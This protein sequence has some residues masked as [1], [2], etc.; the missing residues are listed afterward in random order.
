MQPMSTLL[1]LILLSSLIPGIVTFLIPEAHA[2]L[3]NTL[4][5]GAA[6]VKTALVVV[7]LV[8]VLRGDL[9]EMR[10]ALLPGIDFVLHAD[11]WS[12]MFISLSS[13]LWLLTT[14]YA[15][16]YLAHSQQRSRFFG[17]FSLCVF[18]TSGIALSG[19]LITF[20]IFY[21]LLTLATYPLVVHK[22]NAESI[23]AGRKYLAYTLSGGTLFLAGVVWL[24]AIAGPIEFNATGVLSERGDLSPALLQGIFLLL[25]AGLGVK[26]ALVPL[27]G[28]LPAAM[29]APA[30]VS[31]LLHAVAVVKAGAF[32]I[33]RIVYD[34]YGVEFAAQLGVTTPLAIAASVTILYGSTLALFQDGLKRRLAFSTVSQVSYIALG[35]AIAGPIATIGGIVHLVHQGLMKIT[36]F[37]CAGNLDETLGIHKISQMNGVGRRMPWTM[38]AFTIAALGMIGVPPLAGF[39]SKWYLGYGALET[40]AYWVIGVLIGSSLL[41]AAY[42]LPI[43]YAAWFR[44]AS[45]ER[46]FTPRTGRLE[47][48]WM[49]LLPPL[50]TAA[51]A[52]AAGIFAKSSYSPLEWGKLI[53]A[54]EYDMV[55]IAE[56]TFT[57]PQW[58]I[59]ASLGVP[60]LCAS[61]ALWPRLQS[62]VLR[63][64][65]WAALP[66][67]TLALFP[68]EPA[69]IVSW[70]FLGSVLQVDELAQ[71]FLLFTA[72]L[73]LTCGLYARGYLQD[74]AQRGR[75]AGFFLLAMVGNFGLI[76]AVDVSSFIVFFTLM[77]FASYGLVVH[78]GDERAYRAGRI[79]I[80][81]VVVGEMC[82]FA[83]VVTLVNQ[84]NSLSIDALAASLD[85]HWLMALLLIGF[86]IKAGL[87]LLHV[88]LPLAHPVAP[89]PASAVLSGA[90]VAAGL[91][92]WL[93]FL[94]L[95]LPGWE[96]WGMLLTF[97]GLVGIF[98]GAVVGT[99]QQ[100]AK[101]LLA[102]ST[103]SQMGL[104]TAGVGMALWQPSLTTMLIPVLA[105]YALHHGLAKG[106]LFLATAVAPAAPTSGPIK[107]I[108]VV[109]L[110]VPALAIVGAPL[111]S[112][113]LAKAALKTPITGSE[114]DFLLPLITLGAVGSTLLMVRFLY[115]TWPGGDTRH[116]P[117]TPMW[118]GWLVSVA[119]VVVSAW[120]LPGFD[121]AAKKALAWDALWSQSWPVLLGVAI[122]LIAY[123]VHGGHRRW[124]IPGGD[125]LIPLEHLTDRMGRRLAS[126]KQ[127]ILDHP[128]QT[129]SSAL[130]LT[131]A[132]SVRLAHAAMNIVD[133]QGQRVTGILFGIVLAGLLAAILW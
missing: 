114:I 10:V 13:L 26:A 132:A 3:R 78:R 75:F 41:N 111:T 19:N 15:I 113:A 106:A 37:F 29:V 53:A 126:R 72:L 49:L 28:W 94:P 54:R 61:M 8:S 73:W 122:L 1:I 107:W 104:M 22:G 68:V 71:P 90:M 11:A 39:V 133:R 98:Y 117:D 7:L 124:T 62:S 5:L 80:S 67:L 84:A 4:N 118:L 36:L 96:T 69:N 91:L 86:G 24:T 64:L 123:R 82:L 48:H 18:A 109:L 45:L 70:L 93:R 79:Y 9:F 23:R 2:R 131:H 46:P 129:I 116:A 44:P 125:I 34:V 60:L 51:L 102:Y 55:A 100:E 89:A 83:A 59:I 121:E 25:I 66:A 99:L 57:Q 40:G 85:S 119:L 115:L 105:L 63:L 74:D 47:T 32:G 76:L 101:T 43:L 110:V 77:S 95:G 35:A 33:S 21:E 42:F 130:E 97:A 88:W 27:H 92:G 38:A 30:P 52:L 12:L 103:I 120:W 112:G 20:L 58:L 16:G 31:A 127:G 17:F 87:L 81:L 128:I 65:P 108:S 50:V 6:L 56:L 14:F